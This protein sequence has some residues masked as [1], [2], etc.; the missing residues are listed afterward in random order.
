[1]DIVTPSGPVEG[2]ETKRRTLG[3]SS[4]ILSLVSFIGI[5]GLLSTSFSFI[6]KLLGGNS[7]PDSAIG[8]TVGITMIGQGVMFL[9]FIIGVSLWNLELKK[10]TNTHL[11]VSGIVL[12]AILLVWRVA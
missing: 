7:S 9:C 4:V 3:V 11:A 1:M 10:E 2:G 8:L 5:I 6:N 12:N